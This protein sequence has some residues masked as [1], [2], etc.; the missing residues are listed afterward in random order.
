MKLPQTIFV[1]HCPK[2]NPERKAFLEPHLKERV[3][4]TDVRWGEDFNHDHHFVEWLNHTHKLPYGVNNTSGLVKQLEMFRTMIDENIERAFI[5]T[6]DVMFHKDWQTVYESIDLPDEVMF[7]NLGAS[8]FLDIKPQVGKIHQ[9]YNNGGCEGL[10]A[11][12]QF[13][14]LF[15]TQLNMNFV[16][17]I[18]FHGLLYSIGHPILCLAVC[19]QTS[20]IE[21]KSVSGHGTR[22]DGDWK[23]FVRGYKDSKKVNYFK[24]LEQYDEYMKKKKSKEDQVD[25][26]GRLL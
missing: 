18:I 25:R 11:T 20:I 1:V 17:D 5:L 24:L 23:Q 3:P 10:Y 13:A 26:A 7:V 8:F 12:K 21:N 14:E 6:D 19:Y 22:K 9:I 2:L 4:V 16:Y 15:L